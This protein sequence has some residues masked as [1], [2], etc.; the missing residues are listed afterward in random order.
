MA[1][2]V[3]LYVTDEDPAA[4]LDAQSGRHKVAEW[5]GIPLSFLIMV[6]QNARL[7]RS[8][9]TDGDEPT[10]IA[11]DFTAGRLKLLAFLDELAHQGLFDE[12]ELRQKTSALAGVLYGLPPAT[13]YAIL[14]ADE[15][16]TATAAVATPADQAK[17][18]LAEV[19]DIDGLIKRQLAEFGRLK[20]T[21]E[22]AK[23]WSRLGIGATAKSGA[24]KQVTSPAPVRPP[25]RPYRPYRQ[26]VILRPVGVT[27]V[28][29]LQIIGSALLILLSLISFILSLSVP[30]SYGGGLLAMLSA[31]LFAS[32]VAFI[33]LAVYMLRGSFAARRIFTILTVLSMILTV[34]HVLAGASAWQLI[35]I[36]FSIIYLILLYAE[37]ANDFFESNSGLP[38]FNI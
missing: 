16:F 15:Q 8:T 18:L 17:N 19:T 23:M 3:Y 38:I 1:N 13:R 5:D 14:D 2:R 31:F 6:S 26:P 24:A 37:D 20:A 34:F 28:C 7:V 21:N 36:A 32:Y 33:V 4:Q 29:V 12:A 27:I 22:T 11:G 30:V 9:A 35:S 25:Y 10:A